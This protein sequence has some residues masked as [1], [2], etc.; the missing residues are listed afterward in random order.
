MAAELGELGG[1]DAQPLLCLQFSEVKELCQ[2]CK[3]HLWED[4][5]QDTVSARRKFTVLFSKLEILCTRVM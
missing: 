1:G 5:S 2:F 4:R 3:A